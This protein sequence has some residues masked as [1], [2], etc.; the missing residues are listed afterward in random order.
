[1][2]I[3]FFLAVITTGLIIW[4]VYRERKR[5]RYVFVLA[6][7]E[8]LDSIGLIWGI[9]RKRWESDKD[10]RERLRNAMINIQRR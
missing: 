2:V 10:Y 4:L 5:R 9:P 1:M 7:G 3:E 6:K 8:Y